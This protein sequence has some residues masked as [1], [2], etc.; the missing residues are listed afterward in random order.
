MP[1]SIFFSHRTGKRFA[2]HARLRKKFFVGRSI[3]ARQFNQRDGVLREAPKEG[4]ERRP[5]HAYLP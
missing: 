2:G 4:H 1:L 5:T 3:S